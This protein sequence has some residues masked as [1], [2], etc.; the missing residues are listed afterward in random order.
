MLSEEERKNQFLSLFKSLEQ[1][2]LSLV[3]SS[4]DGHRSFSKALNRVY[5]DHL[6]PVVSVWDNYDFLRTA[7]DLRNILSHE[8]NVCVPSEKFLNR[9]SLLANTIIKPRMAKDIRT[10]NRVSCNRESKVV[11]LLP[12]RNVRLLSHVPVL[13]NKGVCI[14]VFSR[15]TAF[16]YLSLNHTSASFRNLARKDRKELISIYGHTNERFFFVSANA[17]ANS[18]YSLLYKTKAHEKQV[19]LL[20]VTRNGKKEEKLLGVITITDLAK[21]RI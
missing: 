2:R 19:S 20:L 21:A 13:D 7:S 14:G 4:G 9:F 16:D 15:S 8:N 3:K 6:D 10:K 5:Y 11:D 12:I 17:K 18:L 1:K